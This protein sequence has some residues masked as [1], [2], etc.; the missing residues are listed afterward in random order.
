MPVARSCSSSSIRSDRP[1]CS[2]R[3][4]IFRLA[5]TRQTLPARSRAQIHTQSSFLPRER[6]ARSS[7]AAA[8]SAVR[9]HT[10]QT[11][12]AIQTFCRSLILPVSSCAG[13]GTPPA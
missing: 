4:M 9:S 12:A 1:I 10:P 13:A 3:R 5:A 2:F 7:R 11:T 8:V 6:S